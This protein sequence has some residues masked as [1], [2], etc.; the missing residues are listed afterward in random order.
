MGNV[1]NVDK[2]V[3]RILWETKECRILQDFYGFLVRMPSDYVNFLI[4]KKIHM[5]LGEYMW[6]NRWIVWITLESKEIFPD[7]IYVSRPHSYQQIIVDTI[8]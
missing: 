3:D 5:P 4:H 6:M 2:K 7:F 8:F 1:D